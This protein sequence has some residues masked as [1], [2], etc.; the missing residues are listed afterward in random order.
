MMSPKEKIAKLEGLLSRIKERADAPRHNGA[1]IA[2]SPPPEVVSLAAATVI[3]PSPLAAPTVVEASPLTAATIVE[4]PVT[5]PEP[6]FEPSLPSSPPEPTSWSEP[7]PTDA[8]VTIEATEEDVDLDVEV[9]T[10]VV[11][12]EIDIDEPMVAAAMPAESGAQPVAEHSEEPA[13]ELEVVGEAEV[14]EGQEA[15]AAPAANE[16]VEPAPSS[17]PRPIA[18]EEASYEE[19]SA[20]RHTPPPESGKQVAL[21]SVKPEPRKTSNP[22]P[23]EGHTLMGGWHEP[24]IAIKGVPEAPATPQRAAVRVPPPPPPPPPQEAQPPRITGEAT[25][26]EFAAETQVA[27]IE[28]SPASFVPATFGDLLDAT[29]SI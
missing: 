1:R 17:S 25:R 21:P 6:T 29:L 16:V 26:V 18:T 11:E 24:G 4:A 15:Y 20:P 8:E 7:P 22:P 19:E 12:V 9:S 2:P 10:E 3:E 5:N 13:A 23:S 14:E 27:V 28:G